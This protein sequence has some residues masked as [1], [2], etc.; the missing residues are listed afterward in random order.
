MGPHRYASG[1]FVQLGDVVEYAGQRA[2]V[3]LV[4]D[5]TS[6][7]ADSDW[8]L[9]S[10]GP[11]VILREPVVFGRVYLT[12]VHDNEELVFVSRGSAAGER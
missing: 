12:S 3:E 7:D 4:V 8:L 11:G 10:H 1:E 6:V 2:E 5:G 9:R